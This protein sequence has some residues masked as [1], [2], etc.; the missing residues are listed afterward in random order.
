VVAAHQRRGLGRHETP[1]CRDSAGR[2]GPTEF[3]V[4]GEP[5][6]VFRGFCSPSPEFLHTSVSEVEGRGAT[7]AVELASSEITSFGS[8]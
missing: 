2:D 4:K 7:D 6:C 5:R 1:R 8:S 3:R